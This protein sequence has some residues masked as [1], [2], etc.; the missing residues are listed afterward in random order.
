LHAPVPGRQRTA[1]AIKRSRAAE[2]EGVLAM[3]KTMLTL[4]LVATL[5]L[6]FAVGSTRAATAAQAQ[7]DSTELLLPNAD[8]DAV[9]LGADLDAAG[10]PG[11]I[12]R[13]VCLRVALTVHKACPCR[14]PDAN[15]DGQPDGWA[16]HGAYVKCVTDAVKDIKAKAAAKGRELPA[17]CLRQIVQRA[18]KSPIGT[19][20]FTCPRPKKPAPGNSGDES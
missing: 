7:Q 17:Q 9:L 10:R 20:G 15:G 19:D 5:G 16:N 13:R 8:L 2:Q 4:A 1:F 11:L 14:G 12:A 6:A 18:A 3:K